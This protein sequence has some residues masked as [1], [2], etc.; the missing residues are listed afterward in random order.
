MVS[1]EKILKRADVR[2]FLHEVLLDNRFHEMN[3]IDSLYPKDE[4]A[5]IVAV[6]A[7]IKYAILF[8]TEDLVD[9]YI[10]QLRRFMKKS[11]LYESFLDG[12]YR[13][14][15]RITA[16]I[17]NIELE[18]IETPA[19]K[20]KILAY[21]YERY[22]TNGYFFHSFPS[23][24]CPHIMQNGMDPLQYSFDYQSF[25]EVQ[26]IFFHHNQ[27]DIIKKN[28]ND[29]SYITLTDSF[30]DAYHYALSSP[31]Y[32][33]SFLSLCS[34]M[35]D[36]KKY[37]RSAYFRHDFKACSNNLEQLCRDLELSNQEA[38]FLFTTFVQEWKR[39]D[40]SNSV[41]TIL[42]IRR[43]LLGENYLSDYRSIL[44]R[45]DEEELSYSIGR[46]F[47]S[48][49]AECKHY[50]PIS[51][52]DIQIVRFPSYSEAFYHRSDF[53]FEDS[54]VDDEVE[55]KVPERVYVRNEVANAYGGASILALLG[56]LLITLG[57]VITIVLAAYRG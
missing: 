38:T 3:D 40:I 52:K 39:L 35:R 31:S 16:V 54:L 41:P 25:L 55:E 53:A 48:K 12:V 20:R 37:D 4:Y 46:I 29:T 1:Y 42:F 22:I 18:H 15:G 7:L 26:K 23:A 9:E 13:S 8:D 57:T 30:L 36:E 45:C 33:S 56:V 2:E 19:S 44:D 11:F 51:S 50:S 14:L 43:S 21:I 28:F 6:D 24:F 32:L 10:S 49:F 47:A 5:F 17:L 27:K 34:Y